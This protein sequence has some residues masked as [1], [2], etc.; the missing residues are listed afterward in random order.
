MS[1][2]AGKR[3]LDRSGRLFDEAAP[4]IWT[5]RPRILEA[6][7]P[8]L[9]RTLVEGRFT[10]RPWSPGR[11]TDPRRVLSFSNLITNQGLNQ[12]GTLSGWM[13]RC[14]VGTGTSPPDETDTQLDAQI[15]ASTNVPSTQ[16]GNAGSSPNL[17]GYVIKTFRFAQ[18]AAQGNLAEVCVG[19][20]TGA[21]SVS[22]F[23]RARILDTNGDPTT[24]T[25]LADEFLDV[26]YEFRC[27]VAGV[28]DVLDEIEIEGVGYDTVTRPSGVGGSRWRSIVTGS[29]G[30]IS[31][32]LRPGAYETQVLGNINA[33]PSGTPSIPTASAMTAR[34]YNPGD[35][36]RDAEVT[37][38]LTLGNF[39][40]G[41]GSLSITLGTGVNAGL[42]GVQTSFSPSIPKDNE[43]VLMLPLR[44]A[45]ARRAI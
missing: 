35:Y 32:Q 20:G 17:Y 30:G 38:G 12:I 9:F 44:H 31:E 24:L 45:W 29:Q 36:H 14:A 19:P 21:G 1:A 26:T 2:L 6:R 16:D 37:W 3:I 4:V 34:P 41:I 13:N 39:Q 8:L 7:D 10:L 42:G 33:T 27:Y 22:V 5:R 40:A 25:V 15:A 11:R 43:S 28:D 18:G 23:S